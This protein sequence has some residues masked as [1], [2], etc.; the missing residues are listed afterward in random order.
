MKTRWLS[1]G[2]LLFLNYSLCKKAENV[3]TNDSVSKDPV[4]TA[5]PIDDFVILFVLVFLATTFLYFFIRHLLRK[6]ST[7]T[8]TTEMKRNTRRH[9]FGRI[10][11]NSG[12]KPWLYP[13][14]PLPE[15]DDDQTTLANQYDVDHDADKL[16]QTDI[17]TET[18]LNQ[19]DPFGV[20]PMSRGSWCKLMDYVG[21]VLAAILSLLFIFILSRFEE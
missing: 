21:G 10:R 11:R 8:Q 5:S 4:D 19:T 13:L 3:N 2:L 18:V 6:K 17:S 15:Q 16:I 20:S 12:S 14:D 1:V 9:R 7:D